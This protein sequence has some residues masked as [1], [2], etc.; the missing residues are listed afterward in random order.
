MIKNVTI[1]ALAAAFAMGSYAHAANLITNGS[2]EEDV[3]FTG[4]K[5]WEVFPNGLTGWE[6]TKG[7]GIELQTEPTLGLT[8]QDGDYYA[9]LLIAIQTITAAP[10][11]GSSKS[12]ISVLAHTSSLSTLPRA[13]AI[14]PPT[15]SCS[16]RTAWS[17]AMV[18]QNASGSS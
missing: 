3:V 8:P 13:R 12:S 2:F 16:V 7:E 15:A 18:I 14:Q 1:A 5:S 17:M 4:T 6:V 10:T 9:E 11:R